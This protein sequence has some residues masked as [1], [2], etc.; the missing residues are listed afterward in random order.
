MDKPNSTIEA[1]LLKAVT[2][3]I[4]QTPAQAFDP[5][6]YFNGAALCAFLCVGRN[7]ISD[8]EKSKGFPRAI[9]LSKTL[10]IWERKAVIDWVNSFKTD[11]VEESRE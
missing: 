1:G 10:S 4:N 11:S 6:G 3:K 2:D 5:N 7:T 9:R 8:W